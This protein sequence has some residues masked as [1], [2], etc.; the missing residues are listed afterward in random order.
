MSNYDDGGVG[1]WESPCEKCG[2][3]WTYCRCSEKE[4]EQE[5][6]RLKKKLN[7]LADK[8]IRCRESLIRDS[9][10]YVHHERRIDNLLNA[11]TA[12]REE[13]EG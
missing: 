3:V 4:A 5:I 1:D 11:I 10:H 9:R 8:A 13:E 7:A 6:E 12:A 2:F